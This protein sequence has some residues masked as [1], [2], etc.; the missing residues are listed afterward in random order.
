M[1]YVII[2]ILV[3]LC[4]AYILNHQLNLVHLIPSKADI[5]LR[6]KINNKKKQLELYIKLCPVWPIL[7]IK[8]LYDD[9]KKRRQ[10]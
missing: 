10:G 3:G 4:F 7:L 1:N 8:E 2:Y 5:K 6:N 9:I